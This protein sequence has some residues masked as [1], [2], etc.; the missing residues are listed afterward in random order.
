[1]IYSCHCLQLSRYKTRPH[2]TRHNLNRRATIIRLYET[3]ATSSGPIVL[4]TVYES[5]LYG[6]LGLSINATKVELKDAYWAIAFKTHP[7][8]NDTPEALSQF[9]NASYAYKILGKSEQTRSDYDSRYRTKQYIDTFDQLS[10]DVITPFAMEV[11]IPLINQTFRG[12]GAF[13]A[14][15]LK[16]AFEQSSSIFQ[17]AF[18]ADSQADD[19][20]G[21]LVLC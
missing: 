21:R 8:R 18:K 5:D 20:K 13:A 12:I 16:D 6:V 11:A 10:R 4:P 1:M 17:A 14:P 7:D 19:E 3:V 9:R 15:F 2:L